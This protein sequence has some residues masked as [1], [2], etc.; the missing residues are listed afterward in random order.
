MSC[1]LAEAFF[2]VIQKF[3]L[4]HTV[5]SCLELWFE[6]HV[7]HTWKLM[8][9]EPETAVEELVKNLQHEQEQG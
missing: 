3:Q 9:E 6:R 8:G 1:L 2:D 4:S 7:D 5:A